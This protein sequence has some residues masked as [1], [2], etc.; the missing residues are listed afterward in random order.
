DKPK[1]D[2]LLRVRAK[3]DMKDAD[4]RTIIDRALNDEIKN[5]ILSYSAQKA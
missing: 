4:G 1:L 2:E 5:F 3:Y